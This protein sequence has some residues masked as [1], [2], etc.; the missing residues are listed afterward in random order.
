MTEPKPVALPLGYEAK[1]WG[2]RDSNPRILRKWVTATRI[3]PLCYPPII[4]CHNIII[5]KLKIK[6]LFFKI[7][8]V[9][10]RN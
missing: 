3:W 7:F 2:G 4:N 8:L 6:L 10:F 5:Q 9:N 1:W